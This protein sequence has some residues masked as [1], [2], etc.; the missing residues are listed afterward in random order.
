MEEE[1]NSDETHLDNYTQ[2]KVK[3]GI[4]NLLQEKDLKIKWR[5][6]LENNPAVVEYFKGYFGNPM[7]SFLDSYL[8]TKHLSYSY[9]DM[10]KNMLERKRDQWINEAHKQLEY[11]LQ[12]QL[13]DKQC[14]WRAQQITIEEVTVGYDFKVWEQDILNCPFLEVITEYDIELYQAFLYDIDFPPHYLDHNDWQDHEEIKAYYTSNEEE[15]D[16]V[17]PDWYEYHN[18]KTGKSSLLLLSDTIGKKENFYIEIYRQAKNAKHAETTLEPEPERDKRPY[19]SSWD[20]KTI[21]F[22]VD[23]FEDKETQKKY[24]YYTEG[25]KNHGDFDLQHTLNCI[26][27]ADEPIAVESHYDIRLAIEIAYNKYYF[28]KVAAHLP[29]AHEQYLFNKKM[30]FKFEKEKENMYVEFRDNFKRMIL[31]GRALNGEEQNFDY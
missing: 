22:F 1:N 11:I 17:M 7:K 28:K 4:D 29:L 20:D 31:E 12:K 18:N 16:F 5:K 13:F 25:S 21:K 26:L 3:D 2:K 8:N 30:G 6:E 23:T 24:K 14:L 10:Y 15:D 19:L 27:D 9:G